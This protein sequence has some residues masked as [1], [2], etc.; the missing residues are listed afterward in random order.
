MNMDR[1][2]IAR[3]LIDRVSICRAC[4]IAD[5]YVQQY[6]RSNG[7]LLTKMIQAI[8]VDF[9]VKAHQ[10]REIEVITNRCDLALADGMPL[11]W[12]SRIL[13]YSLKE[14][15]G[16]PDFF[17]EFNIVANEKGYSYFFVGA[18]EDIVEKIISKLYSIYPEI[19]IAGYHCPP[20][21]PSIDSNTNREIY[22]KINSSRPDVVWVGLGCPKQEKWIIEN[23]EKLSTA[24][25]MG[26][27][28]VFEFYAGTLQRAP[29]ILQKVGLEWLFRLIMEPKRLWKRYLIEGPKFFYY[30]VKELFSKPF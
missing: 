17:D 25:I 8:N 24:F 29:K 9:I 30:I 20:F 19:K 1:V 3:V 12:V 6:R 15:V 13:G 21:G 2:K 27:G 26:I 5:S 10:S 7:R 4:E 23:K 16:G 28:A 18:T 22:Q 11:V 14:R